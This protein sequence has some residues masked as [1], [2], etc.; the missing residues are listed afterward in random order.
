MAN[1][2]SQKK[3]IKTNE[4]RRQRNMAVKSRMRTYLKQAL[5]A[6]EAKDPDKVKTILSETLS[7]ID[8]A[9]SNGIIHPNSA[10]RKKSMLQRRA[11][12]L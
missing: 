12:T 3:R 10:A 11:A 4:K 7:E 5:T 6:I 2:K 1:I 9:A 8:K